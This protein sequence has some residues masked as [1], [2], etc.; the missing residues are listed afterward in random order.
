MGPFANHPLS[1]ILA[2]LS[3]VYKLLTCERE[4]RNITSIFFLSQVYINIYQFDGL[5]GGSVVK[6]LP[7]NIGDM[8]LIPGW[9]V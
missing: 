8:G 9:R 1:V 3:N 5:P 2:I 4:L 7:A 6:N